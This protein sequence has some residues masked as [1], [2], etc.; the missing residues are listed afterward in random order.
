[1]KTPFRSFDPGDAPPPTADFEPFDYLHFAKTRM[2]G[3]RFPLCLSGVPSVAPRFDAEAF[4]RSFET[5]DLAAPLERWRQGMAA[6]YGVPAEH[7][8]PTLGSSAAVFLA[9][10]GLGAHAARGGVRREVAVESPA[11]GVFRSAATLLG[12]PV[13]EVPRLADCGW[14]LD[15]D[16][17]DAAFARGA[18]VLCVTDLHNPTGAALSPAEVA[19]LDEM[20]ARHGAWVLVDEVYREFLPGPVRTAYRPG[21]RIVVVSSFTKVHGLGPLRAG[22]V[23]AP[24]EIVARAESAEEAVFGVPPSPWLEIFAAAVA[25]ADERRA[26][27]LALAAAGREVMDAWVAETPLVSWTPPAAGLSGLLRVEGLTDSD[28]F[29]ARLRAELDVQVVPGAAFGAEGTIRVSFGLPPDALRAALDVLAL[30]IP[31]LR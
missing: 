19:A 29:A 1:M 30:G 9:L 21:G 10:A 3:A 16:A 24:P 7:A 13:T 22:F 4:R 12:H 6:R 15:L 20:A 23:F 25:E 14:A 31:P 28:D 18:A 2:G 17:A 5:G 8:F 26:R 27:G 11:Y